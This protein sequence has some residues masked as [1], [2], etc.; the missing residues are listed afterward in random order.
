LVSTS[1]AHSLPS[2]IGWW[3]DS[4]VLAISI[5]EVALSF[6][7]RADMVGILHH[8]PMPPLARRLE[9]DTVPP[10]PPLQTLDGRIPP[11]PTRPPPRP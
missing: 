6:I 10:P 1:V 2:C 11:P 8:G 4:I 7:D 5:P 9:C 3:P